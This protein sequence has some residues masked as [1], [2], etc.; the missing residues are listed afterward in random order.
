[1][2][3]RTKL[4][5]WLQKSHGALRLIAKEKTGRTVGKAGRE[6]LT[7]FPARNY[8]FSITLSASFF[9]ADKQIGSL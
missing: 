9:P 1:M 3:S 5:A 7:A 6:I 8:S 4:L 2:H